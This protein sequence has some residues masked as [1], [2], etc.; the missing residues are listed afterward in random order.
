MR[1]SFFPEPG[2][3][4]ASLLHGYSELG[5]A[6]ANQSLEINRSIRRS[7]RAH[8]YVHLL[9]IPVFSRLDVGS[10]WVELVEVVPAPIAW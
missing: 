2:K 1:R 6:I 7:Y 10:G 5:R 9:G 4:S 3:I 8:A